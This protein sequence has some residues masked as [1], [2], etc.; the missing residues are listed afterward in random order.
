VKANL[1]GQAGEGSL[2]SHMKARCRVKALFGRE[3][4]R[5]QVWPRKIID[6]N[7]SS[8]KKIC[9]VEFGQGQ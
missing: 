6:L 1:G 5:G 2:G 9:K 4:L 7:L 3:D 8:D